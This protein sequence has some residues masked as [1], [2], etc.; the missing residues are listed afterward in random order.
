MPFRTSIATLAA[1]AVLLGAC[2]GKP[3][4]GSATVVAFSDVHFD[5]F[6]DPSLLDALEAHPVSE[7]AAIFEA[8]GHRG[9][10]TYGH[11]TN[12]VLLRRMLTALEAQ[13]P[14]PALVIFGGDILV[15]GFPEAYR[16]LRPGGDEAALRAFALKTVTFVV[17][18]VRAAL[19]TT[20]VYFTLGN[21]DDYAGS[22]LLRPDDPFLADTAALFHE[23]LL[24]GTADRAAFDATYRAGG[25][26]AAAVPGK[27]LV[28]VGLNTLFLAPQSPAGLDAIDRELSWLDETLQS[29]EASGKKAWLVMHAPPGGDLATTGEHVD[30]QGHVADPTMLLQAGP[31]QRLLAILAIHRGALAAA[32]TGHTHMDEYRLAVIAMQGLPGVTAAFGNAPAFKTFTVSGDFALQDYATWSL[33]LATPSAS[34]EPYYDFS[35]AYGLPAP[36]GPSLGA[37]FPELMWNASAR[38]GYQERYGAGHTPEQPI[39]DVNWPVYWCG[40]AF[41]DA[42]GLAGCVNGQ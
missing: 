36:L 10:G 2:G 21:W 37:L 5:P 41:L 24:Q 9:P 38:S 39:T 29:I 34:F 22:F 1:S 18:Q 35:E 4:A 19:G 13:E 28:V 11:T 6:Y 20:P 7:W 17:R 32:F 16:A 30:A 31:Q 15:Q 27:D 42:R 12:D 33:D 25:Y 26:Y 3:D 40:I 23:V 8:S 14:R